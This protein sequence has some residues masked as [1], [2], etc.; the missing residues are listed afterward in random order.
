MTR[1]E[2]Y[3]DMTKEH[4][5]IKCEWDSNGIGKL[6]VGEG[7]RKRNPKIPLLFINK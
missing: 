4:P 5:K 3:I 6:Q 2:A 7:L 1:C